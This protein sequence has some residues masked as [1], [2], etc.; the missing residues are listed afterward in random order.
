MKPRHCPSCGEFL[1]AS[2]PSV[3][4]RPN[5]RLDNFLIKSRRRGFQPRTTSLN[6]LAGM[7]QGQEVRSGIVAWL[8]MTRQEPLADF[9][10]RGSTR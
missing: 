8:G 10:S 1:A 3:I 5:A 9:S 7:T 4:R 2:A 6:G